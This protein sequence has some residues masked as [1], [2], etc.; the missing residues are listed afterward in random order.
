MIADQTAR[1]AS[2]PTRSIRISCS[3]SAERYIVEFS[4]GRSD[5]TL[6]LLYACSPEKIHPPHLLIVLY[7][8][9]K[10]RTESFFRTN[11]EVFL[12]AHG[13]YYQAS[14]KTSACQHAACACPRLTSRSTASFCR[15]PP[16]SSCGARRIW[17]HCTTGGSRRIKTKT[18]NS[19]SIYSKKILGKQKH[20]R[21]RAQSPRLFCLG[22]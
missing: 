7:Q 14:K 18:G 12:L 4:S 20:A 15:R 1:Q 11:F 8:H 17:D 16:Q 3:S 9:K 2:T 22:R 6:L 10:S 5:H 19:S 21:G 13:Y